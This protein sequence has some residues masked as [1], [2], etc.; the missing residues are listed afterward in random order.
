MALLQVE[1]V[2]VVFGGLAAL[3]D[4]SMTLDAG[5]VRSVIGPN[6]AGKTT[7]F[8]AITG[9]EQPRDG[10]VRLD[11][12]S[13]NHLPAYQRARIGLRR[14]FQN[15]G[16]FGDMTVLENVM[17]GADRSG[18]SSIVASCSACRVTGRSER[19]RVAAAREML[20]RVGLDRLE[21]TR[22][23]DLSFGQ[24]RMVEIT[25]ALISN[26][27]SVVGRTRS[28]IVA[29]GARDAGGRRCANSQA[30]GWRCCWSSM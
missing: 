11:G 21:Q 23:R 26:L 6:G 20:A 27:A 8:N 10:V 18:K 30:R 28:G 7:L 9:Y 15:G 5:M 17:V 4:V 16:M 13:I 19:R 14:T 12:Q 22:V 29:G 24:Q 2:S 25:R 3:T 1:S